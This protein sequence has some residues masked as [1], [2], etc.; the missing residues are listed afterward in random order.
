M[1]RHKLL[2]LA[3]FFLIAT[4]AFAAPPEIK[5]QRWVSLSSDSRDS[6]RE[7]I[8]SE[9]DKREGFSTLP[10]QKTNLKAVEEEKLKQYLRRKHL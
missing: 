1:N 6:V 7:I 2:L 3:A 5:I 10:E 9:V 4:I 8:I